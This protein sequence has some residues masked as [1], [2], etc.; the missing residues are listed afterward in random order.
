MKLK[1]VNMIITINKNNLLVINKIL[2]TLNFKI[3]KMNLITKKMKICKNKMNDYQKIL[4]KN[5]YL[6][7]SLFT[8]NCN[9]NKNL[10][11]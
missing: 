6:K 2:I 10:I 11:N 9:N 7:F 5:I 4:G 1:K 3:N 8:Q